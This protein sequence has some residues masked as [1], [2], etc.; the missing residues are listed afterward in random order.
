MRA[1]SRSEAPASSSPG[2]YPPWT[3]L[4]LKWATLYL[5]LFGLYKVAIG[6]STIF[7]SPPSKVE[8]ALRAAYPSYS[9]AQAQGA[10]VAM[11]SL[12]FFST[13]GIAI[14]YGVVALGGLRKRRWAYWAAMVLFALCLWGLFTDFLV[15]PQAGM[16]G[17]VQLMLNGIGVGLFVAMLWNW[18][19]AG[20]LQGGERGGL[21]AW[22][23]PPVGGLWGE[24][25][26]G[27]RVADEDPISE[28]PEAGLGAHAVTDLSAEPNGK[29]QG[30]E[31]PR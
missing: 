23:M 24:P 26:S 14:L 8:Q 5:L 3:P 2:Q 15:L 20:S 17:L 13:I 7:Q 10:A 27:G 29:E 31:K 28:T 16:L 9:A 6:T 18:R 4:L 11:I 1:A 22:T 25:D 12:V 21:P 30:E 19:R